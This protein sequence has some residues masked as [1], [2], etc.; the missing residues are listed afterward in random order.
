[1]VVSL[2]RKVSL[3][4]GH[5]VQ[6]RK[7]S[8]EVTEFMVKYAK[9]R[10]ARPLLP[11]GTCCDSLKLALHFTQT[12]TYS[13]LCAYDP[14]A[15]STQAELVTDAVTAVASPALG[16]PVEVVRRAKHAI[17]QEETQEAQGDAKREPAALE[18]E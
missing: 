1:M 2:F 10:S 12:H 11:Y 6:P 9:C 8:G 4:E 18:P 14:N 5:T 7:A 17:V 15:L 3:K 16:A 13:V